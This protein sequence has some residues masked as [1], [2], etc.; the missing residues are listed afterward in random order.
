[1]TLFN[2]KPRDY[3]GPKLNAESDYAYLERSARLEVGKA[4]EFLETCL[5]S[6]PE[7]DKAELIA[8][9][10]SRNDI[11]FKSATFE[12]L[13]YTALTKL[14]MKL[15]PHPVLPNGRT[16]RPDFLVTTPEH[17]QFY[18][19]A[20]LTSE[21]DGGDPAKEA[22]KAST[23]DYLA[24][25]RHENFMIS[26]ES[27]GNPVTQPSGRNLW[28]AIRSFLDKLN[29]DQI[30]SII[31]KEGFDAAPAILWIHEGWELTI[32]PIPLILERRGQARI[33][34][35]IH[36]GEGALIDTWSPIRDTVKRKAG[37][38]G[39][40]DIPLVVAVNSSGFHLD[41]IDE[42]Q[43]LYG[44][45]QFI[46]S[47]VQPDAPPKMERASN[48]LWRGPTG[49]QYA[50]ISAVWIFKD[51]GLYTLAKRPQTIY[52]NPW[53]KH[54]IPEELKIFSHAELSDEKMNWR[55]GLSFREVFDLHENWPED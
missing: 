54:A 53:A 21:L 35:G 47:A 44:Q 4:R 42:M 10:Q 9:I 25:Q 13:L 36:A 52:L 34:I 43:A 2:T 20:V 30:Q 22:I 48:G 1:M 11:H 33:L 12:L 31:D 18:L 38:Y 51:M 39:Q 28:N 27:E 3:N 46:F 45:E 32:R 41:R 14:G 55:E 8:R 15:E 5:G 37:K 29:P 23:L 26:L 50:R 19:E 16:T 7:S 40:L 49:A 17:K 24:D 6:Y